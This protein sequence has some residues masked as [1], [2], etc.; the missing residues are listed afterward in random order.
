[1]KKKENCALPLLPRYAGT[2]SR[3]YGECEKHTYKKHTNIV[4]CVTKS[5]G[6]MQPLFAIAMDGGSYLQPVTTTIDHIIF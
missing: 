4:Y 3:T 1:M 6:H 2:R 5:V